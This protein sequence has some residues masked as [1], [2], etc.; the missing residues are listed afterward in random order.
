MN[1]QTAYFAR[2]GKLNAFHNFVFSQLIRRAKQ[3]GAKM[4]SS[5]PGGRERRAVVMNG[6][7]PLLSGQSSMVV[8]DPCT[9]KQHHSLQMV[10]QMGVT[11]CQI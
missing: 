9:P 7:S 6:P 8:P 5:N 1:L 10:I 11:T 2:Q 3:E 4:V